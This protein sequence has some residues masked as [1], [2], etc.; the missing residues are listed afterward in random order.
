MGV[1]PQVFSIFAVQSPA[2]QLVYNI[3]YHDVD[4][5][6]IT[7]IE[8][9]MH[10]ELPVELGSQW[11]IVE[12]MNVWHEELATFY[13]GSPGTASAHRQRNIMVIARAA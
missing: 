13:A 2:H 10:A 5:E 6:F 11:V 1:K 4:G 3:E 7:A 8:T 12:Q 9:A